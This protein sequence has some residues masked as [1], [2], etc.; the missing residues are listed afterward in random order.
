MAQHDF[1]IAN[2]GGAT[3]RADIN[4]VLAAIQSSNSGTGAPSSTRAG[5]LWLDTSGGL[6]YA[7]KIRDG[8]N[9]HWLT[10]GTVDDPGSDK[11]ME[12]APS[13]INLPS[14]GGIYESD[15][16]TAI[17]TESSGAVTL[18]NVSLGSSVS[19]PS[20]TSIK[21]SEYNIAR[22]TYSNSIFGFDDTIPQ[23][24][25]GIE[26]FSVSY[27]PSASANNIL[28]SVSGLYL[29]ETTNV[30]DA[31][32]A[33][34]FISGTN[35]AQ[36]VMLGV[37]SEFSAGSTNQSLLQGQ[38][39]VSSWSGA[40]TI[41]VRKGSNHNAVQYWPQNGNLTPT[42]FLGLGTCPSATVVVQ[43]IA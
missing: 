4:N 14:S 1:N 22:A 17:L 2:A 16:S 27:T 6:P 32:C 29:S 38:V 43:E 23:I 3:V 24:S 30:A 7:L 10:I 36:L 40:K 13:K 12:I 11:G 35:D 19:L 5:M 39:L 31:A 9:N 26:I 28:I 33:A 41:S 18:D 37:Y 21:T 25:E 20:G 42:T 15:G 8:G 34:L